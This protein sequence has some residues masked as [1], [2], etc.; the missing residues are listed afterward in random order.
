MLAKPQIEPCNV[1]VARSFLFKR[2][3][4]D[5]DDDPAAGGASAS[6]VDARSTFLPCDALNVAM[7]ALSSAFQA[8][9]QVRCPTAHW[10]CLLVWE[11]GYCIAM[12]TLGLMQ[13]DVVAHMQAQWQRDS[14]SST[15]TAMLQ[16][17]IRV[18]RSCALIERHVWTAV[19]RSRLP[20]PAEE[21]ATSTYGDCWVHVGCGDGLICLLSS[22]CVCRGFCCCRDVSMDSATSGCPAGPSVTSGADAGRVRSSAAHCDTPLRERFCCAPS[23]SPVLGHCGARVR[24]AR[25]RQRGE[26][27]LTPSWTCKGVLSVW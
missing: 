12:L 2:E 15:N 26:C 21:D 7:A 23:A 8:P 6:H 5:D 1:S 14:S 25:C 16:F 17:L 27:H 22:V 13:D 20:F 19:R 10:T 18:V 3:D 9:L 24:G 11:C 4:D